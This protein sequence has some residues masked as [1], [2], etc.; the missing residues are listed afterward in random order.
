MTHYGPGCVPRMIP[1]AV[2]LLLQARQYA[3]SLQ[4]NV[5]EFALELHI[6][7]AVG[8]SINDLRWL[9]C[10]G[11]VVHGE[12]IELKTEGVREFRT[13]P[14]LSFTQRS[15]FVL[16]HEGV[17]FSSQVVTSVPEGPPPHGV[18][19]RSKLLTSSESNGSSEEHSPSEDVIALPFWNQ[20]L[21]ELSLMDELVKRYRLPSPNQEMV[22]QAFQEE[23]W[24]TR[25][26]DPLPPVPDLEPKRRLHDTIKSL[27][28]HQKTRFIRF[29]GDGRGEGVIWEP[30]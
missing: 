28:R 13:G 5:W 24:P 2:A 17:Q 14:R 10:H 3:L 7:L 4:T 29:K 12:E 25:V 16:T 8:I 26:D 20:D 19:D 9:A 22:L 18:A 6:F 23:D 1:P 30:I 11:F 15:C 21:R 27:N